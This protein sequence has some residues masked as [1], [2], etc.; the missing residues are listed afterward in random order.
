VRYHAAGRDWPA[1]AESEVALAE[2]APN[3]DLSTIHTM[4]AAAAFVLAEDEDGY[5]EA[6]RLMLEKHGRT[7]QPA[8]ADRT[9]K[10]CCLSRRFDGDIAA[11]LRLADVA[12]TDQEQHSWYVYFTLARGLA[13]LRAGEWNDAL[14]WARLTR[15]R[16]PNFDVTAAP[17]RLVEALAQRRLDRPEE[18]RQ[19]LAAAIEIR[20]QNAAAAEDPFASGWGEWMLFDALRADVEVMLREQ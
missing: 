11:V 20:R 18:S 5:R 13:A 14:R 1:L 6:C 19:A 2:V 9:V 4:H 10:S 12:V 17:A 8:Y 3:D 7:T 16:A 15:D